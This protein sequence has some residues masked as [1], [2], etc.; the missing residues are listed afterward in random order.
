[1]YPRS[2]ERSAG[3]IWPLLLFDRAALHPTTARLDL[4]TPE[5][6]SQ[7]TREEVFC[8]HGFWW[9]VSDFELWRRRRREKQSATK[10]RKWHGRNK[11]VTGL[12]TYDG[13][14]PGGGAHPKSWTRQRLLVQKKLHARP[15][16][17]AAEK[18]SIRWWWSER[19]LRLDMEMKR[20]RWNG[21]HSDL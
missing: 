21:R 17:I 9:E 15:K 1:M 16:T 20:W 5:I 14:I 10:Q 13:W 8:G 19:E 2:M 3:E 4:K 18:E 12:E 7:D 6:A 11:V